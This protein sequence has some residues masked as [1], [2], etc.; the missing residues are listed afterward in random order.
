M[1]I[2][3]EG[4]LQA[5]F[6]RLGGVAAGFQGVTTDEGGPLFL[7]G[8]VNARKGL[9]QQ[10]LLFRLLEQR[11]GHHRLSAAHRGPAGPQVGAGVQGRQAAIQPG[12]THQGGKA[13]HAL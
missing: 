9:G 8:C 6:R 7:E 10:R 11:Q 4:E 3:G 5:Q 12:I 2:D 13:I 1:A